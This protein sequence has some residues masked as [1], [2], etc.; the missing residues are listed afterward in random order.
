VNE[1]LKMKQKRAHF[2]FKMGRHAQS[3]DSKVSDRINQQPPGWVFSAADFRDLGSPTAVRLAL[4]RH[5]KKGGIRKVGRG[6]YD[7][8]RQLARLSRAL[9]PLSE[10]VV[11]A[12]QA[13]DHSRVLP[14]GAHAANLL[15]LSTQVPVRAVYLTDGRARNVPL[16]QQQIVFKHAATRQMATAGRVSGTVIQALRWLGRDHIDT[17]VM[18]TLRRRLSDEDKKQLLQD[19]RYA[20]AWIA[21]IMQQVAEPP[22]T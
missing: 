6:L 2:C 11:Q 1:T 13:R 18:A 10:N 8:P 17:G 3:T 16:G 9:P 14:S 7:R 21:D 12:M 5:T 22:S 19:L 20:P 15:G 4:M